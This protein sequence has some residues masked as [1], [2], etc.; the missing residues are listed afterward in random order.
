MVG[1][2]R[3][4]VHIESTIDIRA[5]MDRGPVLIGNLAKGNAAP[6]PRGGTAVVE[7]L[8]ASPK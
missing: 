3:E 7:P 1:A 5:I 6:T 4:F 2:D 8:R